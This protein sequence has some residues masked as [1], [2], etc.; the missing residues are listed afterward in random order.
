MRNKINIFL[1]SSIHNDEFK[2]EREILPIIIN[3][4]EPL[5]SIFILNK[6]EDQA[7]PDPVLEKC[8][9]L[10]RQSRVMILLLDSTA[11]VL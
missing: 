7:A 3:N 2:T 4:K 5:S 11:S 1:S 8:L 10:V 6:I 9:S